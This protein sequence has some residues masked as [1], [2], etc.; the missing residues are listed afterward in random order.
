MR[1]QAVAWLRADLALWTKQAVSDKLKDR[2][3]VQKRLKHWLD[4]TDLAGIRDKDALAK[5]AAD[6]RE[7][8]KRLWADVAELLKKANDAK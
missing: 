1:Q 6:E 8:C 4:D 7:T 3:L 2:E 5:L